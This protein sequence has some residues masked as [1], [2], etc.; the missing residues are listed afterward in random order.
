MN[1][2]VFFTA[3]YRSLAIFQRLWLVPQNPAAARC[4]SFGLQTSQKHAR[5]STTPAARF[6]KAAGGLFKDNNSKD[7]NCKDN[8]RLGCCACDGATLIF[9]NFLFSILFCG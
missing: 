5:F 6:L 4:P 9:Q 3:R 2:H 8:N 7:N 1:L